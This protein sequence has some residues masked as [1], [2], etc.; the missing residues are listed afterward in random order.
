MLQCFVVNGHGYAT[1]PIIGGVALSMQRAV[2][3]AWS[4][5]AAVAAMVGEA[6]A[7][8]GCVMGKSD[9]VIE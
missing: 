8:L 1:V 2:C 9:L 3:V 7:R 5:V 6:G 4:S